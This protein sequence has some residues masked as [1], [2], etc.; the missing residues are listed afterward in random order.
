MDEFIVP[1]AAHFFNSIFLLSAFT[2]ALNSM[3]VAS[4][5][6]HTL[7]LQNKTGPEWISRRLRKCNS[8][9]PRRAVL[10]TAAIALLGYMGRTGKPYEAS[11]STEI[12]KAKANSTSR[13]SRRSP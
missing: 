10:A 6:L 5:V 3:F 4:R 1:T 12:I 8:G 7:A 2:C 9:V 13:D 11:S